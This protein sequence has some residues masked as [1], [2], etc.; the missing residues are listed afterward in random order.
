MNKLILAFAIMSASYAYAD[1]CS[2][3]ETLVASCALSGEIPHTAAFCI[4]TKSDTVIYTFKKGS[5]PELTVEFNQ[6]RKLKRW[7]DLGTYTT[8]LGFDKGA[9]SYVLRVPE[10]KPGAVAFLDVK[11]NG[12]IISTKRCDSNSFGENDIKS[13]SIEDLLDDTVRNNGF[14]FP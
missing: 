7:L 4:N 12:K 6:K 1:E 14:K 2:I 10:E 3:N 13:N 9:Y 8:Y 11:K 5:V